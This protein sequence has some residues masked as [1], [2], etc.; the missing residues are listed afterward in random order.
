MIDEETFLN[1]SIP[2]FK[3]LNMFVVIDTKG[4]KRKLSRKLSRDDSGGD[5]WEVCYCAYSSL[6]V[7]HWY[8]VT[9]EFSAL[10]SQMGECIGMW[11]RSHFETLHIHICLEKLTCMYISCIRLFFTNNL[12]NCIFSPFVLQSSAQ[13][14]S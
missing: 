1:Y 10:L 12:G 14:F 13:S 3:P 8:R 7:V 2:V 4:L 6:L 9:Y 11:W 5:D